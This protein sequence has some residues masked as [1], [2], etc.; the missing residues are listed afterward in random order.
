MRLKSLKVQGFKSF[1]DATTVEFHDGIT[2]VVGPNG[3]GK[4]NISDAI[5]WVL[6]EQRPTAI[7]GAKM[8]EAIF[9]GSVNRR[10]VNRGSVS[11][12][13]SNEDGALP[14]AYE[15]VEIGRQVF[16]DG[17]SEYSINRSSVR[18]KDIVE[19]YRD[20]GLGANAYAM[21]EQ[22]MVDAILSNRNEERRSLFEEA[23]GIG[24]YKDR[25]K[26]A[27]RRLERAEMDLQRLEDVIAEIQTK[28]RSLARQK[29]KA[30]RYL[31][32]RGH[33]N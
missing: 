26:S 14:I 32:C 27:T 7:R 2:A 20:T 21:I 10:P 15:E 1:A 29:G 30:Q 4:S 19:L 8:E 22:R 23:A 3:C 5:R 12:T 25:R 17:G 11:L 31:V 6:G 24:K 13:V 18:L 33:L 16:R 28:V 9:Q